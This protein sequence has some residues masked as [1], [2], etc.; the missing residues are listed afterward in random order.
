VRL[1]F[2]LKPQLLWRPDFGDVVGQA[3]ELLSLGAHGFAVQRAGKAGEERIP[4][5]VR[6]VHRHMH[7]GDGHGLG[8]RNDKG[9]REDGVGDPHVGELVGHGA[10]TR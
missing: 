2:G 8:Q 6:V 7:L 5:G 4:V 10:Q 3:D 9:G 1:F